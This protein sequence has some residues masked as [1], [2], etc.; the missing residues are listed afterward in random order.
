MDAGGPG[1]SLAT[2]CA[3][4]KVGSAAFHDE[5]GALSSSDVSISL[6]FF[7]NIKASMSL[8]QAPHS[9]NVSNDICDICTKWSV[10]LFNSSQF[11]VKLKR[12][13]G[14]KPTKKN[15]GISFFLNYFIEFLVLFSSTS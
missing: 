14:Y 12:L 8:S 15:F 2:H 4:P 5:I 3:R 13:K 7:I 6:I 11:D 10:L 9:I 1:D